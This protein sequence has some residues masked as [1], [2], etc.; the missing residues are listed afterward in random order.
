VNV[1]LR[2]SELPKTKKTDFIHEGRIE[3]QNDPNLKAGKIVKAADIL[4]P[5]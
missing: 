3:S 5:S 2:N 4:M 1:S